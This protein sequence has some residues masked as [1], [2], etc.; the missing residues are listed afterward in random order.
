MEAGILKGTAGFIFMGG[1]IAFLIEFFLFYMGIENIDHARTLVVTSSIVFQMLLVFNCKSNKSILKSGHN[2]YLI[3]AVAIS[4][5]M[6]LA[7][8]YYSSVFGV[9]NV[10][11]FTTLGGIDWLKIIGICFL[12]F[13]LIEGYKK[14]TYKKQE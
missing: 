8:I 2:K 5:I 7:A 14:I 9:I 12:G 6:H 3:Y 1:L 4:I 13:L 11:R 10:F